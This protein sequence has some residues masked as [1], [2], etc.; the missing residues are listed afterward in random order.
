MRWTWLTL[1]RLLYVAS[2]CVG[3][4]FVALTSYV[5]NRLESTSD[6]ALPI[7]TTSPLAVEKRVLALPPP[8]EDMRATAASILLQRMNPPIPEPPPPVPV[9]PT[10][11]KLDTKIFDGEVIGTIVDTDPSHS[12]ALIKMLGDRVLL[13]PLGMPITNDPSSPLVSEIREDE[14]VLTQGSRTQTAKVRGGPKTP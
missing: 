14:I 1:N 12:Y 3:L 8:T 9:E 2:L 4:A 11:I 6:R 10:P 5:T 13:V 7:V